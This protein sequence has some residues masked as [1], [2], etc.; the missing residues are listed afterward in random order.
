MVLVNFEIVDLFVWVIVFVVVGGFVVV[1]FIVVGL[2]FVIFIFIVC[3][4]IKMQ[5]R[6]DIFE[7]GEFFFVCI[8]VVFV[9]MVAGYFGIYFFGFVVV[10]V[11]L[12]FGFVVVFFFFVIIFGIFDKWMN[13][14]GVV[15]GMIVGI[16]LMFFYMIKFKFDG[17]GGGMFE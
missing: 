3:D 7:K 6:L 1:L 17:F 12:A 13:W 11:A 5:I 14:Q 4:L 2:L 16:I 8:G 15:L 10:V 9:V